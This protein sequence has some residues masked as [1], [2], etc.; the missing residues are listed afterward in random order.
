MT[1]MEQVTN[2]IFYHIQKI[3]PNITPSLQKGLTYTAGK[4]KKPFYFDL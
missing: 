1:I 3:K 2:Q 4:E